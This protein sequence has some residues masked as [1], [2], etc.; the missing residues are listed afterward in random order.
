MPISPIEVSTA[1]FRTTRSAD[2][3]CEELLRRLGYKV[4]Y[5]VARLALARSLGLTEPP[6]LISQD[7]DDAGRTIRGQQLF[8]EGAD[9]PAWVALL[10]QRAGNPD[11]TRRDLQVVVGAHWR[12]GAELLIKDWEEVQGSLPRF[13]EKLADVASLPEEAGHGLIPGGG[14]EPAITTAVVIPVGEVA[15]DA[16]TAEP[17]AFPVNAPGGSP[18]IAFMG[19][20][21]SGKT[22]TAAAMLKRVRAFG[23]LPLLAF[24]FKGDLAANYG[25][26][27]AF[28]AQVIS[29]PRT[30]VPLDVLAVTDTDD[31]AIAET[32][33]RIRES[34]GRVKSSAIGGVQA[35]ALR[36]AVLQV[37]RTKHPATLTDVSRALTAEYTRRNRKPDELTATLNELTQFT[38]FDP[39]LTPGDFFRRSWIINLPP[40]LPSDVRRLIINLTLDALDRWLNSLTDSVVVDGNRSLRHVCLVDEAHMILA[41]GLPAL[42]NLVRMSRSKGGLVV[43]VSQSPN[44]F[45]NE[46]DA[47]LDNVGLTVAFNTNAKPGP[48]ARIF[49]RSASLTTLMP[50]EAL[51]RIRTEAKT[52]RIIAWRP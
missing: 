18:H 26:D 34:I 46:D 7:D 1:Q 14:E 28:D 22:R 36:V 37:L 25:L 4:H 31:I 49:G 30:P 16:D 47:F 12:R 2:K 35:D 9:L 43:L 52:R 17:V 8:G 10:V 6:S 41:S 40:E 29:P 15:E 32:A 19:G 51:C 11:L 24:D 27:G 5:L 50:G 21:G 44:D 39:R 45:E 38:L 3:Q 48:T 20:A 42:G 33:V 13:I 23:V